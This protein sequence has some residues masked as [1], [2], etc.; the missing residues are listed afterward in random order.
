MRRCQ[1]EAL[2]LY[3]TRGALSGEEPG[4]QVMLFPCDHTD[5]ASGKRLRA[6]LSSKGE[7]WKIRISLLT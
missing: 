5:D 4:F 7:I 6:D 1:R 3:L 2:L